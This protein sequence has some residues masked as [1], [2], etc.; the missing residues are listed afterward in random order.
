M[1]D[2]EPYKAMVYKTPN[3]WIAH[4]RR[5]PTPC[6]SWAEAIDQANLRTTFHRNPGL[7]IA[8][9]L[10]IWLSESGSR[11]RP[12][13]AAAVVPAAAPRPSPRPPA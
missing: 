11:D 2:T 8:L 5:G 1:P 3:G 4:C 7:G 12:P 13:D 6:E 9:A 10:G